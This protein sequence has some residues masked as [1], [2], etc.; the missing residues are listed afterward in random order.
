VFSTQQNND[1]KEQKLDRFIEKENQV[2]MHRLNHQYK[3]EMKIVEDRLIHC[4]FIR[5]QNRIGDKNIK[6]LSKLFDT[7]NKPH[8]TK[9]Q[10]IK[11]IKSFRKIFNSILFIR[12]SPR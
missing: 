9:N 1:Y 11:K 12:W 3:L 2:E 10:V 4:D 6:I 7:Q 5:F 8:I